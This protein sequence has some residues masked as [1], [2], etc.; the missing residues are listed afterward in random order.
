MKKNGML[1][2]LMDEYRKSTVEYQQVL[3]EISQDLFEKITDYETKNEDC[4][5]IQ[6][7]TFHIIQSGYTY[8]NYINS[9]NK[10][11]WFE[12]TGNIETPKKGIEEINKMLDFTEKSFDGIWEK[13]NKE[14]EKWKFETRWNVTYD[15]EQLVE[16]AIVHILRHRRQIENVIK[17]N[18]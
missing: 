7:I 6:N 10:R 9:V 8:S 1:I 16:H 11:E 13:T 3:T 14:I 5:S 17:N 4:K 15:F 18:G 2:A 12:Y